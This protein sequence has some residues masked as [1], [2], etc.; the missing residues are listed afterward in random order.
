M[1]QVGFLY[2]VKPGVNPFSSMGYSRF[3]RA[4]EMSKTLLQHGTQL[5]IYSPID[6]NQKNKTVVGFTLEGKGFKEIETNVP[7]L[8]GN[9]YF[10]SWRPRDGIYP[11]NKNYKIWTRANHIKVFLPWEFN[12]FINDKGI[13]Y[14]IVGEFDEDFIPYS[15][16]YNRTQSQ[17]ERFLENN[18]LTF[19]KPIYGSQGRGIA[20]IEKMNSG[21]SLRIYDHDKTRVSEHKKIRHLFDELNN[22][23]GHA[24]FIIQRGINIEKYRES[25]FD[26]R[27]IMIN[28]GK[29]WNCMHHVRTGPKGS[30]LS[31]N[32]HDYGSLDTLTVLA[33]IFEQP[34]VEKIIKKIEKRC[35][36]LSEYLESL[37]PKQVN[38]LAYDILVDK[39]GEIFLA[40]TNS[41][42]GLWYDKP[43]KDV[44]NLSESEQID[45]DRQIKPH[46]RYLGEFMQRRLEESDI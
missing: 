43:F 21:F 14:D 7:R 24:K 41:Q 2:E 31:Y 34:D 22:E 33:E 10:G 12:N 5:I 6:V 27:V 42:P 11:E 15:E 23:I 3:Y 38:E 30:H 44:F 36:A 46:G 16:Y 32:P 37:Y 8:N 9:W 25:S 13:A 35:L 28:D 19:Y 4:I 1:K 40:E 29:R 39:S 26:V 18:R 45:Y 17:T 20:T